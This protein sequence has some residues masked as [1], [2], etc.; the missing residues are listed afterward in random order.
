[1]FRF[2]LV[3]IPHC[4]DRNVRGGPVGRP[5]PGSGRGKRGV[6]RRDPYTRLS[7]EVRMPGNSYHV[8]AEGA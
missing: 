3:L 6:F 2:L 5:N 4:H 8:W 1:M 7:P